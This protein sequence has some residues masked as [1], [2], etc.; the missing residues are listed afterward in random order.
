[1]TIEVEKV[2]VDICFFGGC[3]RLVV[4]GWN[5]R[6]IWMWRFGLR[7]GVSIRDKQ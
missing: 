1:V 7:Q 4:Y 2:K 6:Y 3:V 5:G